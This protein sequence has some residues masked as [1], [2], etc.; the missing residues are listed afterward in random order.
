MKIVVLFSGEQI[1]YF[2]RRTC[3][4]TLGLCPLLLLLVAFISIMSLYLVLLVAL[5]LLQVCLFFPISVT[6]SNKICWSS[7]TFANRDV[8]QNILTK[9]SVLTNSFKH[10]IGN[11]NVIKDQKTILNYTRENINWP[12]EHSISSRTTKQKANRP[13]LIII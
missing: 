3:W 1:N 5:L 2:W 12:R 13:H 9:S 11:N 8:R 6:N 10:I 4:W 7:K